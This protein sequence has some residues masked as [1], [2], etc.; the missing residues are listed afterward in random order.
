MYLIEVLQR[1]CR[2]RLTK[3][4]KAVL[5]FLSKKENEG[6]SGYR[7]VLELS[8]KLDCSRAALYNAINSLKR[9]SLVSDKG[10]PLKLTNIGLLIAGGLDGIQ[11]RS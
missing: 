3:K 6:K 9:C 10:I 5:F 11:K 8:K 4:Q 2:E 1:L 7:I